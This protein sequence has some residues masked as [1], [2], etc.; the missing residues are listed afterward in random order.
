VRTADQTAD[1]NPVSRTLHV[2]TQLE[3]LAQ[4][5]K[6]RRFV[7]ARRDDRPS[8]DAPGD[9]DIE[10]LL[11]IVRHPEPARRRSIAQDDQP[12][13]GYRGATTR[14]Q[15][16]TTITTSMTMATK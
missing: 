7:A 15:T 6:E 8:E 3:A 12:F 10:Q 2:P 5:R 4:S 9:G 14:P 1:Q 16:D 11:V 13:G